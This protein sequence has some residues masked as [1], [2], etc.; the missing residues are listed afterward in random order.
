MCDSSGP[1]RPRAGKPYW[2]RSALFVERALPEEATGNLVS[3]GQGERMGQGW[4][5]LGPFPH[6]TLDKLRNSKVANLSLPVSAGQ[7]AVGA[8]ACPAA[9]SE[10]HHPQREAGGRTG[11]LPRTC[12]PCHRT[13]AAGTAGGTRAWGPKTDWAGSRPVRL[14][15]WDANQTTVTYSVQ[16]LASV[17][18]IRAGPPC[19]HT[20][21]ST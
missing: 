8:P 19:T 6:P 1:G 12:S 9:F 2:Q 11:P 16:Q 5:S 15:D 10:H 21:P 20:H 18:L 17:C 13:D 3:L 4:V 14:W 7:G